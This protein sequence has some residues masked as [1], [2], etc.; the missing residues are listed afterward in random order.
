VRLL[1][2]FPG[3]LRLEDLAP[4]RRM[5]VNFF[6]SQSG[7]RYFA[8]GAAQETDLS[9]LDS[10]EVADLS[11]DGRWILFSEF[12]DAA[13]SQGAVYLRQTDGSPAVR[14]GPGGALS[15]SAD[16]KLALTMT[17]SREELRVLPVGV[18]EPR[19][20]TL[21]KNF[22]RYEGGQWLPDGRLLVAAI[23]H[24]NDPRVYVQKLGGELRAISPPGLFSSVIVS[25]DGQ[26]V[27]ISM[28]G[29]P[30]MLAVDG[31]DPV[32]VNGIEAGEQPVA[33]STD[34]DVVLVARARDQSRVVSKVNLKTGARMV[35]K[36]I[37]PAD[38]AGVVR[39][40]GLHISRDEKSYAY[41]YSRELGELYLVDGLR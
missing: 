16:G 20:V 39:L 14:L 23:E 13:G 3:P 8:P 6:N 15:L 7:I 2:R 25:P 30:L 24:G 35:W 22:D 31:G 10:S 33:W 17:R 11:P 1:M 29:K 5:L 28:N 36:T 41:S 40:S 12:G 34:G 21:P 26:R 32:T 27:L 18:G 4:D 9:W 19:T 38:L 37:A